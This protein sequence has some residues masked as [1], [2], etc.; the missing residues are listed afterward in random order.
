MFGHKHVPSREGGV[1]IV[2]GELARRMA[3]ERH[4][5]TIFNRSKQYEKKEASNNETVEYRNVTI[6][7]VFTVNK[8][9]LAAMTSSVFAGLKSAFGNYDVVHI[10]AEGPAF[11]SWLPK[12]MG[13]KVVVTIHGLDWDR[14]KWGRFAA[15][16]I[17]QGEKN[18][19]RFADSIIVLSQSVKKYFWDKY[20][21]DTVFIPNGV[22]K[23]QLRVAN[24]ITRKW[25]LKKDSY[26]LYLGR[27]VPE[28]GEHYLIEAFKQLTTDK[29]LVIPV[30]VQMI[31]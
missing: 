6:K 5:V 13:K 3:A 31:P 15:W 2:V 4:L 29:K 10:H 17:H 20:K 24:E 9:G 28:K 11:M 23:P 16:Y 19:V 26:V 27:I 8:R 7:E 21:R 30:V 22:G 18:A 1:E 25:G 14:A 12:L